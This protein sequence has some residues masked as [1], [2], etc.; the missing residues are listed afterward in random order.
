MS[1]SRLISFISFISLISFSIAAC[2]TPGSPTMIGSYPQ[3]SDAPSS[4]EYNSNIPGNTLVV[5]N[6]YMELEVSDTEY[7][8]RQAKQIVTSQGGY[9]VSSR[10]WYSNGERW[11]T[12]TLAVPVARFDYVYQSLARLGKLVSDDVSGDR[13]NVDYGS[14]PYNT[15]SN[16][17]VQLRPPAWNVW[18]GV[19]NWFATL[20]SFV[21]TLFWVAV[22]ATPLILMGVGLV[23]VVRWAAARLPKS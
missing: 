19:S 3:D 10:S 1:T 21:V 18:Q 16:I 4:S 22:A 2:S 23:T 8:A 5:Y 20:W 15:F 17:T 7:A 11:T 9:L 6:A 12:L 14:N 13:I